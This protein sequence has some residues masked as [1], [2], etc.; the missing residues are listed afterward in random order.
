[1]HLIHWAPLPQ[2]N[3]LWVIPLLR[4][5]ALVQTTITSKL[6]WCPIW[7]SHL[8]LSVFL[9][10]L[11]TAAR[12]WSGHAPTLLGPLP[13]LPTILRKEGK[14]FNNL[15]LWPH[16][17]SLIP[18]TLL[19][20]PSGHPASP[21]HATHTNHSEIWACYPVSQV[22]TRLVLVSLRPLFKWPSIWKSFPNILS[23]SI[24]HS[25]SHS[26]VLSSKQF[27]CTRKYTHT[28]IYVCVCI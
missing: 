4:N 13:R 10:I 19:K 14:P 27:S 18:G 6:G 15:L 3:G 24:T 26:S 23:S 28:C 8:C 1:M 9:S 7:L 2:D 12:R 20:L 25:L 11:H 21:G 17:P 5:P 22:F 16:H